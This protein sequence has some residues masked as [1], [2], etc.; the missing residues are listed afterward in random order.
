MEELTHELYFALN[1]LS[2]L[3]QCEIEGVRSGQPTP[4]QWHEA[5][6]RAEKAIEKYNEYFCSENSE[7]NKYA[8]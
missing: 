2:F 6:D 3:N 1:Q 7:Y 8:D 5:F 4:Q